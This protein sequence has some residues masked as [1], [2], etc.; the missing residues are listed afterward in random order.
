MLSGLDGEPGWGSRWTPYLDQPFV[1]YKLL[2]HLLCFLLPHLLAFKLIDQV[3]NI[4]GGRKAS[5]RIN[6]QFQLEETA[7]TTFIY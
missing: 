4:C 2:Q 7:G 1:L 6:N 5:F 3:Q